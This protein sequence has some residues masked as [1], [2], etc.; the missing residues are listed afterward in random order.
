[1]VYFVLTF[2]V[3]YLSASVESCQKANF[4][5]IHYYCGHVRSADIE[6]EGGPQGVF[7]HVDLIVLEGDVCTGHIEMLFIRILFRIPYTS[8]F[9]QVLT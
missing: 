8:F 3:I 4:P 1:M 2:T 5:L 7:S 9:L 6:L